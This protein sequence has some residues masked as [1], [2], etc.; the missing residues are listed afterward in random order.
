MQ[1]EL[2]ERY[3]NVN[4]VVANDVGGD[5]HIKGGRPEDNVY[6]I[7]G[8]VV[9]ADQ[10]NG[11]I[12]KSMIS[13]VNVITGGTPA[14]YGDVTGGI[15]EI[16]TLAGTDHFFGS[17]QGYSSNMFDAYH[18][19]DVNFSVGAPNW[20]KTDTNKYKHTVIDFIFGGDYIYKRDQSPSFVG[21]YF[22]D[23]TDLGTLQANPIT[24]S[25]T[26]GF[27]RSAEFITSDQI[28]NQKWHQNTA[29]DVIG[30]NGKINFHI[31]DLVK[32]TMGGSYQYQ[33]QHDFEDVYQMFN[34]AENPLE[35]ITDYK[36]YIRF[37]QRFYT[38]PD[39]KEK[40]SLIKN[41]FYSL[42]AEY[43]HRSDVTENGNFGN[44][45]FRVWLYRPVLPI[46]DSCISIKR[47]IKRHCLLYA[48]IC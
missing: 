28:V 43:S 12:P 10:G 44:N 48:I 1:E 11:S 9:T 13:D 45:V 31:S 40:K 34:S 20:T 36:G 29:Q 16:N 39:T 46:Q 21:T 17:A 30:V 27:N 22:L 33:T 32:I 42:Q 26:G 25:P 7:D 47:R 24:A 5:I 38:P 2:A 41:A 14:K 18:N 35:N 6:V 15:I 8:Q 4:G 37:T 23:P 19:N 3:K